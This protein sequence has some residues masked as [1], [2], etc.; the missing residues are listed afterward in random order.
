[1]IEKVVEKLKEQCD[2]ETLLWLI[3]LIIV[4]TYMVMGAYFNW[5]EDWERIFL[6]Q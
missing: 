6:G 1:M 4:L 3:A 2:R 5:V